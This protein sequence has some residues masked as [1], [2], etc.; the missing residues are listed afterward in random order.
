MNSTWF[1]CPECHA[2]WFFQFENGEVPLRCCTNCGSELVETLNYRPSGP[3]GGGS[4]GYHYDPDAEV[5]EMIRRTF[6][7]GVTEIDPSERWTPAG[8][9]A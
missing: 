3:A 6:G 4:V 7:P 1:Y 9:P 8:A 2:Q 5:I